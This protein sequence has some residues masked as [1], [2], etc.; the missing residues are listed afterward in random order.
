M[1]LLCMGSIV[2]GRLM[3]NIV[4]WN[5]IHQHITPFRTDIAKAWYWLEYHIYLNNKN[6]QCHINNSLVNQYIDQPIDVTRG[7]SRYDINL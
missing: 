3:Q 7:V 6:I 4:Q 1:F 5:G 2:A